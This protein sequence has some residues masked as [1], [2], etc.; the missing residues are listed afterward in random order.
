MLRAEFPGGKRIST[1]RGLHHRGVSASARR[2][3]SCASQ[4]SCSAAQC[5]QVGVFPRNGALRFAQ[6]SVR[7]ASNQW[8][9]ILRTS[10]LA[11]FCMKKSFIA[12]HSRGA[13]RRKH[14]QLGHQQSFA[15]MAAANEWCQW[16]IRPFARL[17]IT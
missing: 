5:E 6:R 4:E 1:A 13:A 12:P 9:R 11:S 8:L 15:A 17:F 10:S 7:S 2:L 16:G 14:F 3:D